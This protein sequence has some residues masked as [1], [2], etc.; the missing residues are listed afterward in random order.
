MDATTLDL[1]KLL[2]SVLIG[3]FLGIERRKAGKPAGLRTLSL[4][5]SGATLAVITMLNAFPNDTSRVI[6]GILTGIGFLGAGAII[7]NREGISGLTTAAS[8]WATSIIGVAIGL[9][10]FV[11]GIT[12]AVIAYFVLEMGHVEELIVG[13]KKSS[14]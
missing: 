1:I 3:A 13:R 12:F 5:S 11:L 10:E 14:K 2:V 9:G 7:S 4:V 6:Q 8:I